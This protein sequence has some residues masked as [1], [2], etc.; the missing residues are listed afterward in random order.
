MNSKLIKEF[1][2]LVA[3]TE[4][5]LKNE[6]DS[7][8]KNSHTCRLKNF[9]N[10]MIFLKKY[11]DEIVSSHQLIGITNIGKGIRDRVDEILKKGKLKEVKR[12]SKLNKLEDDLEK[13]ES[14]SSIIGIGEKQAQKF[15]DLGVKS[16]DDLVDK[17]KKG[18]IKVNDK[19]KLG[20]K[21]HKVYKIKI[22]RSEMDDISEFL[23]ES[24]EE[25]NDKCTG[26]LCGSYR[27]EKTIS[28]D[29]DLLI[30]HPKLKTMDDLTEAFEKKNY[31]KGFINY[32]HDEKFLLDDLTG[33]NVTTKYMGFC[34]YKKHS[35]RRIDIRFVPYLSYP[36]S[37][38]YFTGSSVF[39]KKMRK[40]A[41]SF[42]MLLNEYGL[43]KITK[44]KD[45][46]KKYKQIIV[47]SEKDVFD[48]LDMDYVAPKNRT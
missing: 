45:G 5:N 6:K 43:Y 25:Y 17:V 32:L 47:K 11:P 14:I 24:L 20:L 40:R 29:I 19:I 23:L 31:L 35:I 3:Q 37:L 12:T 15:I 26:Q 10:F 33:K 36:L 8:V 16:A 21:Y 9:K 1:T 4:E 13:I 42:N 44:T 22:P 18:K 48:E 46:T 30:T 38:L 34:R 39:N 41:M 27:R 28:N 7:S 2:F